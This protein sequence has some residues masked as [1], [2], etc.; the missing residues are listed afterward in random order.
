M[1]TNECQGGAIFEL[2][3]FTGPAPS[4]LDQG[5]VY[6]TPLDERL[7]NELLANITTGALTLDLWHDTVNGSVSR[8]YT[9]YRFDRRLNF[10]LPYGL[11]LLLSLPIVALGVLALRWNGVSAIDGGFVQVLMTAATGDTAVEQAARKGC[12]GGAESVPEEFKNLKVRFGE[13]ISTSVEDDGELHSQEAEHDAVE[14]QSSRRD[15]D[16]HMDEAVAVSLLE[17]HEGLESGT[18]ESRQAPTGSGTQLYDG[19]RIAV[20]RAGFGTLDET[21]PF[22]KGHKLS[23]A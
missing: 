18:V 9:V 6:I 16:G 14:E 5:L 20:R 15:V 17:D 1:L 10:F 7:L 23:Q 12:F 22:Q 19:K 21:V 13:L 4:E 3:P 8:T 2:S 11:C